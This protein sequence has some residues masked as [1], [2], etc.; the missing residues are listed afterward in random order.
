MSRGRMAT[1]DLQELVRLHRLGRGHRE[2]ARVLRCS[3]NTERE[4]R[5]LLAGAGLLEGPPEALPG[6]DALRAAVD[7]ARPHQPPAHEVS[8]AERWSGQVNVMRRAG[9]GPQVIWDRLRVSEAGFDVS[10]SAIKRLCVKQKAAEP[11]RPEDVVIPVHTAP[12]DVA[13]VDFGYIGPLADAA[14]QLH[15]AWVFVLVLGHSRRMW[16]TIV[17]D[18]SAETWARVHIE[19]FEALGGV[20]R[21]LVPDNLKAAV[22]RAAFGTERD[23]LVVHQGYRELARHYGFVVDPAPVRAP[24]KKGKVES[25]VGYLKHN[26]MPL[27]EGGGLEATRRALAVWL[28]NTAN[29]RVHGTTGM[30]P[31]DVFAQVEAEALLRLPSVR[32]V[33]ASWRTAMVHADA[34]VLDGRTRYSVP[35]VHIGKRA[36]VRLTEHRVTIY[37][38]DVRVA[39][40]PRRRSGHSTYD[41]HLPTERA[42]LRHRSRDHWEERAATLGPAVSAF[43]A[44]VFAADDVISHLRVVQAIVPLLERAGPERAQAVCARADAYGAYSHR[45]V[46]RILREGLDLTPENVEP[47]H[48]QLDTARFARSPAEFGRFQKGG[49]A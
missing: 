26:F 17:L 7:Q 41:A 49:S 21:T 45:S 6:L 32:M 36:M 35:F 34:H 8:S 1:M 25:G 30:R 19:A 2:I 12:G 15:K 31:A 3:P 29:Q 4:Y 13:Q 14:G 47:V 43:V 40:H 33:V 18:Q 28:D 48:G 37:I 44:A 24:K 46:A 20:P 27:R 39:E 22:I 16:A 42:D 23:E 38:D 5:L 11:V 10:L 9:L